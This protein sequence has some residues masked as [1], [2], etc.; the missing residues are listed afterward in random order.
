MEKYE[1]IEIDGHVAFGVNRFSRELH[2]DEC[3]WFFES[4]A[5]Y[6]CSGLGLTLATDA[7]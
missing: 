3:S 4:I 6:W 7:R 5:S 2:L 1:A